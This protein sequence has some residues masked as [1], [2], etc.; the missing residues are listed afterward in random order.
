MVSP[1]LVGDDRFA[2]LE[3]GVTDCKVAIA[4]VETLLISQQDTRDA[5]GVLRL[6]VDALKRSDAA[7]RKHWAVAWAAVITTAIAAS[8]NRWF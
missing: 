1:R 4:R 3:D 8:F 2:R 5:V 7:R 6:E